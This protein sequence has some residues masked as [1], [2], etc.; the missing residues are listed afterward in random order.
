M[1]KLTA[2]LSAA[3]VSALILGS[4][5]A[6]Q[7]E[8]ATTVPETT[9]PPAAT[10]LS[11]EKFFV[12]TDA[13]GNAVRDE[14]GNILLYATDD[15]GNAVADVTEAKPLEGALAVGSKIE[16]PQFRITLPEGWTDA[17]STSELNIGNTETLDMITVSV[18]QGVTAEDRLKEIGETLD[19]VKKRN[20]SAVIGSEEITVGGESAVFRSVSVENETTAVYL[21][22]IVFTH[23]E[24]VYD[25]RL[26]ADRSISPEEIS[27][28]IDILKSIEF[29]S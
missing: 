21:G 13:E 11:G 7:D 24:D 9:Q 23:G 22:Y 19:S 3:L 16:M 14:E 27:E 8:N 10:N 2:V 12:V 4:C 15:R 28:M 25:C 26:T 18:V 20:G 5:G 17:K 1:K 29:V 6:K